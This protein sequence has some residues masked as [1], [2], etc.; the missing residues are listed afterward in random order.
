M[1]FTFDFMPKIG[2]HD[3]IHYALGCNGGCGI[4]M[5]SWLGR[6]V[7]KKILVTGEPASALESLNYRGRAFYSG[8]PWFLPIVGNWWRFRD[9]LEI[10]SVS[11]L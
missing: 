8:N 2:I 10:R 3:G 5:M 11:R 7:A 9:W 6:K 4:V 1:A